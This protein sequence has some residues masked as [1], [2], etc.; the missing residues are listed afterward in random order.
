MGKFEKLNKP[1]MVSVETIGSI[2]LKVFKLV[3][4]K[5]VLNVLIDGDDKLNRFSAIEINM[6]QLIRIVNHN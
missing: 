1:K 6:I 3:S 5:S 4:E 2:F